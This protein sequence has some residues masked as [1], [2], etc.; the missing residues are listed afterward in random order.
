MKSKLSSRHT[1]QDFPSDPEPTWGREGHPP[2]AAWP[3]AHL[4]G[5]GLTYRAFL[6]LLVMTQHSTS[7]SGYKVIE[8]NSYHSLVLWWRRNLGLSQSQ[9]TTGALTVCGYE[10]APVCGCECVWCICATS[11]E[12]VCAPCRCAHVTVQACGWGCMWT[13]VLYSRLTVLEIYLLVQKVEFSRL[14]SP[15]MT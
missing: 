7:S 9:G 13:Q 4:Y 10:N 1:H 15:K 3:W 2:V 11:W 5:Q 12:Y 6:L 8:N 14:F